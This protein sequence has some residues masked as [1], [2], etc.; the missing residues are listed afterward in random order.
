MIAVYPGSFDPLTKGHLDIVKRAVTLFDRLVIGVLDNAG[1]NT[2]FSLEERIALLREAVGGVQHVEVKGFD[3]LLVD[4]MKSNSS[5]IAI[6]GMRAV[7]DFDY[8]FQMALT[9]KGLY[10]EM[11]TV[12]L[13]SRGE[14]TFISSS[15]V[16][17]IFRLGGNVGELVPDC[18]VRA[19]SGKFRNR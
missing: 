19:L 6:R 5:R 2:L 12:F 3:G 16:K 11:E 7:S 1:K 14:F 4:F 8:E 13:V 15:L 17:E 18:V 9:N 10:S